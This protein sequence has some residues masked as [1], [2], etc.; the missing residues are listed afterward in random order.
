MIDVTETHVEATWLNFKSRMVHTL[1]GCAAGFISLILFAGHSWVL[2]VALTLTVL[3]CN[4][5]TKVP[6]GWRV[7]PVTAALIISAG[8]TQRTAIGGIDV[9][10]HRTLEVLL[11]STMALAITWI[12]SRIWVEDAVQETKVIDDKR[13]E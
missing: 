4:Y 8:L 12:V 7:A 9:A 10:I 3:I 5:V 2:P 11:G 13:A 6:L 1:V